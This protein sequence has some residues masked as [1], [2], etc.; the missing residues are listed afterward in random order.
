MNGIKGT[1][2]TA[3]FVSK[4]LRLYKLQHIVF[5][6]C[7]TAYLA[8]NIKRTFERLKINKDIDDLF[9][10]NY[11]ATDERYS[12]KIIIGFLVDNN[13]TWREWS[14]CRR[15]RL[16]GAVLALAGLQALICW[17]MAARLLQLPT[18]HPIP[19][20]LV[21]ISFCYMNCFCYILQ[22]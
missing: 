2:H 6:C 10:V 11:N 1:T 16:P 4:W 14:E 13:I 22:D 3:D 15:E 9:K 19:L 21:L 18:N 17:K 12:Y 5:E 7:S 20:S 8:A